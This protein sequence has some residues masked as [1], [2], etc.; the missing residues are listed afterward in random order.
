VL[1]VP[2][3]MIQHMTKSTAWGTGIESM[4]LAFINITMMPWF[5]IWQQTIGRDLLTQKSFA[6]TP[7]S[8]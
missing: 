3:F 4:M 5:T 2:L 1:R 6:R 8:S 7:R